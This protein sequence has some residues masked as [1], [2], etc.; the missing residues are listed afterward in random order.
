MSIMPVCWFK[1]FGRIIHEKEELRV[2]SPLGVN[3]VILVIG[4]L[5]DSALA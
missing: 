1:I 4:T 5:P 3:I 2:T